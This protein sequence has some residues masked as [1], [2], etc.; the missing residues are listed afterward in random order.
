MYQKYIFKGVYVLITIGIKSNCT[1]RTVPYC[2]WIEKGSHGVLIGVVPF[3]SI[4]TVL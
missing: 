4:N 2:L 1:T 3:N